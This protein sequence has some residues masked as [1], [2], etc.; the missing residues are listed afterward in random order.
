M[1][2]PCDYS[3]LT[4]PNDRSYVE[5]AVAYVGEVARKFG[6]DDEDRRDVELAV[7]EAV[8]NVVEHA[9]EPGET[10]TFDVSCE[11]VPLGM[12]VSVRDK[13][14]PFDPDRIPQCVTQP[15]TDEERGSGCGILAMSR[16]M[17]EVHFR[18]LGLDGKEAVL[19]KYFRNSNLADHFEA[20]DLGLY[21]SHETSQP[22]T[23]EP[24]EITIRDMRPAEALEV[25][26]CVYR[27]YGYSHT[28]EDIYFPERLVRLNAS[29][30]LHS[31]V[32]VTAEDELAGHCALIK[33]DPRSRVAEIG[34]GAVKP[35][36]RSQGILN[37]LT[38]YL[39]AEA[40]SEGLTGLY[41][42]A[43]TNHTYSQKT[44]HRFG[45]NDCAIG[46][47]LVPQTASFR[48]IT[49]RL[50]QRETLVFHFKY[51]VEPPRPVLFPPPYHAAMIGR[52]YDGLG[53]VPELRSPVEQGSPVLEGKAVVESAVYGSM[54]FARIDVK[55]YGE[56][57][58]AEVRAALTQFRLKRIE[59]IH[60][61][62]DLSDSL[63]GVMAKQFEFMG[64]FFA[65]ILP[66]ILPGDALILQYLNNVPIE[67]EK[68]RTASE[69]AEALLAYIRKAD[70]NRV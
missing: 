5:T 26:R 14:L 8:T 17:D 18:N 34:L 32:A 61:Y 38:E 4:L 57:V 37:R 15:N 23:T 46:L 12:Q 16:V 9:Y 41:G 21:P 68:I 36:F 58:V 50:T 24:V 53:A 64:F 2:S 35:Q 67:Y 55:R 49:E 19:V 27:T 11:R 13:G 65:G 10:A 3:K 44:G 6:F 28:Y 62:L 63:T 22:A 20:C 31:A 42:R 39:M 52:L 45:M 1:E 30:R 43:V 69:Q 25:S 7:R 48:G 56:D 51:L 60:L 33:S 54:G 70:P 47:G 29:G 40:R 66:G 59:I